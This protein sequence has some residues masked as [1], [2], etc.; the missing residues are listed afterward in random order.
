MPCV[1]LTT[2]Y[3]AGLLLGKGAALVWESLAGH[4][5]GELA[6]L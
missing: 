4:S 6:D 2:S 5:A 1:M 3:A